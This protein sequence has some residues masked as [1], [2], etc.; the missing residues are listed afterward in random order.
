MGIARNHM[1][2]AF[3]LKDLQEIG[4]SGEDL[5]GGGRGGVVRTRRLGP[6]FPD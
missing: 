3:I 1:Q 4:N 2:C 5:G 6:L